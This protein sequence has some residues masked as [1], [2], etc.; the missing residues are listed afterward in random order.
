MFERHHQ[1]ERVVDS[2]SSVL[3]FRLPGGYWDGK[4]LHRDVQVDELDG[5]D[6]DVLVS[7]ASSYPM[8]LNTI[9]G[10]KV[11][12]IGSIVEE[13]AIKRII[14]KLSVL[15]RAAILLCIRR[16]THGDII[17]GMEVECDACKTKFKASPDLSS[18]TFIRPL[19]PDKSEYEFRLPRASEKAERDI[20]V[21]WHVY[22]GERETRIASVSKQIGEKDALTWRMMGRITAIDGKEMGLKDEH[23]TNDGKIRQDKMLVELYR[24]VKL[25]SQADRNA[26][27]NEFTRVEGNIDLTVTGKC[28]NPVCPDPIQKFGLDIT[29]RSFF[30]PAEGQS[31]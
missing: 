17:A 31:D 13:A 8:R 1:I 25:M 5:E 3:L 15:D 20:V 21:K 16:V 10:R 26:L 27:R 19:Q 14:P 11:K 18:I 23:F 30:F 7:D 12:Q 2:K 6:E 28:E 22:D 4:D 24:A 9:M 29:G